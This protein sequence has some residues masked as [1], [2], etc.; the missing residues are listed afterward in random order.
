MTTSAS[1]TLAV[2]L[3]PASPTRWVATYYPMVAT[4]AGRWAE[5]TWDLRQHLLP[6]SSAP[7]EPARWLEACSSDP[8]HP[9]DAG[10]R[11]WAPR[12]AAGYAA[13]RAVHDTEVTEGPLSDQ[14]A[15][16]LRED[17]F[18][19]PAGQLSERVIDDLKDEA[20]SIGG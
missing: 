2:E 11:E 16:L 9:R 17:T 15:Q 20:S 8:D 1:G 6:T 13:A 3:H 5:V 19:V 4:A 12:L 7:L 14:E 10:H 18:V